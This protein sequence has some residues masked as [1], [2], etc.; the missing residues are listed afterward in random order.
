MD[1]KKRFYIS[2]IYLPFFYFIKRDI[3]IFILLFNES[4]IIQLG[5]IIPRKKRRVFLFYY[6]MLAHVIQFGTIM[7][8]EKIEFGH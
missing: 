4:H 3:C 2:N 7:S 6:L 8:R 1:N 5:T